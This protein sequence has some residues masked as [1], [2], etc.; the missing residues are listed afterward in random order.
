MISKN[1]IKSSVIYTLSGALPAA[2][3]LILLPFYI[4]YLPTH[5]YGA[6]SLCLAISILV[7]VIVTYSFDTSLYIHYHEFKSDRHKL[8]AFISSVFVFMLGLGIV[9]TILATVAGSFVYDA[10]FPKSTV[11]FFPYGLMSVFIGVFQAF[12][13]VHGNLLQTR[14]RPTPYL[15][16]NCTNFSIIAVLTIIGLKMYPDTL[17]GPLGSRVVAA[18]LTGGWALSQ[19][20]REFGVHLQSPW[21]LTSFSFNAYTFIYQLQQWS[22]NYLDRFLIGI[23]M[24][25]FSSVGIYDFAMKCVVPIELLLN[26]LNSAIQPKVIKLIA[27]QSEKEATPE[28]NRYFYGQISVILLAITATILTIPIAIE[29][30]VRESG[31]AA[32]ISLIPFAALVYVF[33]SMRLYFVVPFTALK[34]M[35]LLTGLNFLVAGSKVILMAVLIYQFKLMGIIFSAYLAYA[36][37]IVLLWKGIQAHYHVHFNY[38][39]LVIVPAFVFGVILITENFFNGV[40]SVLFHVGYLI[41]TIVMLFIA[42]RRELKL[43]NPIIFRR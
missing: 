35:K 39:K 9:I 21:R 25:S 28:I 27:P 10:V 38:F 23:F 14:E 7:Q 37:E 3:A 16:S 6:L 36:I 29:L 4:K 11:T 31:Y 5:V 2:S 20:F 17:I 15:W 32:A 19:V 8:N 24:P 13:K 30:F 41:L 33:K 34:K 40:S 22:I 18:F 26:G 12:F 43:L 42:Y 1:F